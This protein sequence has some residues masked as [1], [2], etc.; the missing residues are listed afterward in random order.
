MD[1]G[2]KLLQLR[3]MAGLT[4]EQL[5]EKLNISRQTLSKWETGS[6][7]PDWDSMVCISRLFQ[8]SLDE[9]AL[10]EGETFQ[11][12]NEEGITIADL[13]KI[14]HQNKKE[15]I[16]LSSGMAFLLISILGVIMT[17]IVKISTLNIQYMLYRYIVVTDYSGELALDTGSFLPVY[18][19][20]AVSALIGIGLLLIYKKKE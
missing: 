4:Q 20:A 17:F 15:S 7:K 12:E 14:N 2:K 9:L 1:T 19:A 18:T 8:I 10:E 13:M 6:S 11:K 3:K 5:A 16:L